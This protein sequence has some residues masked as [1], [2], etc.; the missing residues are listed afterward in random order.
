VV[1][2]LVPVTVPVVPVTATT[3]TSLLAY[4]GHYNTTR[5]HFALQ[6]QTPCDT[7]AKHMPEKSRIGWQHTRSWRRAS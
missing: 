7:I 3:P 4:L 5:P 6:Y 1:T 2:V